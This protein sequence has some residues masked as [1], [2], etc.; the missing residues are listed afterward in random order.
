VRT[1]I[2][3]LPLHGGKA[4]AWL[5]QRMVRLAREILRL[6]VENQGPEEV[7]VR[8]SDPFW[9]QA[10][11]CLLGFDWHSSGVT[12][13]V[14]GAVAEAVRGREAD[15][16]IF[17]AGGKGR[18][19]RRTP[20]RIRRLCEQT[21]LDAE[22]LVADSRVT[23]KVDSAAVQ[24]GY[25]VYQ[26]SF[27]FTA[28]GKWA[29]VQ[30]GMNEAAGMARRYHW[31]DTIDRPNLDRD[32]HAAVC[33]DRRHDNVLNLVAA[34]NESIRRHFTELARLHPDAL[35]K[36][37][38]RVVRLELP[39]RHAVSL[40]DLDWRRLR[41][42]QTAAYEHP[43]ADFAALLL[44]PGLGAAALRALTLTAELLYGDRPAFRDPAR[45]SFAHGGKDGTPYPVHREVYD[46]TIEVLRQL[47]SR[48]HIDVS[49]K[50]RA[51][52][53]LARFE[54]QVR[55]PRSPRPATNPKADTGRARAGGGPVQ[56]DLFAYSGGPRERFCP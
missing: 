22:A 40:K 55:S 31:L 3:D 10:L 11:G 41:S 34:E 12:T 29:V 20:D 17:A 26:H 50:T 30:Q 13:T 37:L 19:S 33:C 25:Q 5:F 27:F 51:F 44:T 2:A 42:I 7:L 49:D 43:P 45:F 36:E 4:P 6:L 8:L 18:F 1:G 23:A 47:T 56:P 9:F 38:Q 15:Y 35:S 53:R 21:G 46:H 14:C 39:R 16:G 48:S 24:D 28:D 32:P 52:R 54:Q